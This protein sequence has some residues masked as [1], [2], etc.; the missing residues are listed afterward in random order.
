MKANRI[1]LLLLVS[2]F[3]FAQEENSDNSETDTDY[4]TSNVGLPSVDVNSS[5][6]LITRTEVPWDIQT[7]KAYISSD[8]EAQSKRVALFGDTHVHTT[9]SFDA[10]SFGTTANPDDAYRFAKGGVVIHP[11]GF[12]TQ[13]K[14]PLDFYVVTDHGLFLGIVKEAATKGTRLYENESSKTVRDLNVPENLTIESLSHRSGTFL[15]YVFAANAAVMQGKLDP[16]YL[17]QIS[18]DAWK[19]IIGAADRHNDPGNFTTFVGYEYT[20]STNAMD[21]LHR[22]V[23]FRGDGNRYPELP[24][25]RVNSLDPEDLWDWM[26]DL[27]SQGIE[28]M[29]IPHNSNGSGA[30]MFKL[31]DFDGNEFDSEYV[32]KRLRNEPIVEITQI[33]GTSDT[34]PALSKNDEWA[35]FE[36]MP[37]KVATMAISKVEGGSY[38][39]EAL[40]NGLKLEAED[41]GNPFKFG[42]IGSTDGHT[43][44]SSFNEEDY[45]AKVGLLDSTAELRG[46]IPI[47]TQALLDRD[48]TSQITGGDFFMEV[49]GKKYVNASSISYGASG[50]AGVWAEENTRESI[51]S[52]LRRKEAFATS[53]PRIKVRFFAGYDFDNEMINDSELVKH[54]YEKGHSMGSD[55]LNTSKKSDPEFFLWAIQDAASAPLQ[56]L[57][58]IK[59][60]VEDGELKEIVFDVACSDGLQVNEEN[61]RCPDNGA[62]VNIKDCSFDSSVGASELKAF[63]KD[64]TYETGQ[65]AF[66]YVRVLENPTCRW[67]TWDSIRNNVE[68]RS[69]YPTTIQERAWSSPIHLLP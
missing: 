4:I 52:A 43:A 21:N 58:I 57:Q 36:I 45:F 64:P 7:Q 33:K 65:R 49:D 11:A 60:F 67:S 69:D 51:Y 56:R 9:Y 48:P 50:L 68:P 35:D 38:V 40:L 6:F 37:W 62:E 63:W 41:K 16:N 13:L 15:G 23:I 61:Y 17:V 55:I 10:Y 27:R 18:R 29:A 12:K 59:G 46:S 20:S 3:S 34:H 66:Y 24:F 14:K 53:G 39:R 54:L 19:D 2:F 47:T 26:D 25:S 42:F 1:F 44:A 32:S 31:E 30:Q 22:N 5:S 28:S 8:P